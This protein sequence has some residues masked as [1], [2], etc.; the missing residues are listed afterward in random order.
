M[1]RYSNHGNS[2]PTLHITLRYIQEDLNAPIY[3]LGLTITTGA[4]G[5]LSTKQVSSM[6]IH[7]CVSVSIPFLYM[8]DYIVGKVGMVNMFILGLAM[9]GVR[10]LGY[11]YLTCP[12]LVST[13]YLLYLHIYR[14]TSYYLRI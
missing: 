1:H 4:L 10:Y 8:S 12:W 2:N 3:L 14:L 9:Y 5:K 7:S 11:S 6:S 13:Q